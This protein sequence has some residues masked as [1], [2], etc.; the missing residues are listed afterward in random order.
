MQMRNDRTDDP[1]EFAPDRLTAAEDPGERSLRVEDDELAGSA[2]RIGVKPRAP[3]VLED[4]LGVIRS[5]HDDDA[6]SPLQ[7]GGH[8]QPG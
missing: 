4:R 1:L 7:A 3:D 6:G 5:R 8:V 2:Q